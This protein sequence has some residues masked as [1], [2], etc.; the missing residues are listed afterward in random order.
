MM[1]EFKFSQDYIIYQAKKEGVYPIKESDWGRLKRQITGIVPNNNT[2][3][4][5]SSIGFGIFASA[6]FALIAFNTTE[7]LALW[8]LPATWTIFFVS[9]FS[10]IGFLALD[11]FQKNIIKI[12][13]TDVLFEMS[14]IEKGFTKD[15]EE[16][17]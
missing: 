1:N 11:K 16:V 14:E 12:S 10:G 3:Q 5:F 4:I 8:A 9:L 15:N 13:S 2:F 17:S 6:I 7:K